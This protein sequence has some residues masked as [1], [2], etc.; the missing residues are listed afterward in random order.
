M[1]DCLAKDLVE[2]YIRSGGN[3]ASTTQ[4]RPN[5]VHTA[6]EHAHICMPCLCLCQLCCSPHEAARLSLPLAR[7][8]PPTDAA[9]PTAHLKD[10]C[11]RSLVPRPTSDGER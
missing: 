9:V 3:A 6:C 8:G 2:P 7:G 5:C 10:N 1:Y 11:A 4:A